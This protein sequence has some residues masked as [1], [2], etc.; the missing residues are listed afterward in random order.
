LSRIKLIFA[1]DGAAHTGFS[2]V[3]NG[4]LTGLHN[5]GR[6]DI[7]HVAINF[8]DMGPADTP[9]EKIAAGWW[10]PAANGRWEAYDAWGRIRLNEWIQSREWDV[11]MVLN[12]YPIAHQYTV[13]DDG[14]PSAF[15]QSKAMKV[16][17]APLDSQPCPPTFLDAARKYDV[18]IFYTHW[19]H[20]L[21]AD[22]DPEFAANANVLYHGVD[23]DLYKPMDKQEAKERLEE[24]FANHNAGKA[25][26]LK[27]KFLVYSVSTNQFRKDL[28]ALFRAYADFKKK[29]RNAFLIPHTSAMPSNIN[30]GWQLRNLASL[31]GVQDAVIMDNASQFSQEEMAVF[32][33]AADVLA[34]P[35][36]GEGFGIPSLEAMAC[37]TPVIA[38]KFGPQRE[39]H[40]NGRGY[41]IKVLD[42][43]PGEPGCLTYFALPDWKDLSRQL[44]HVYLN[45]D[46][47]AATAERGYEFAQRHSWASKAEQLDTIITE[48]LAN[49]SAS[50]A[51]ALPA[52]A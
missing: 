2:Q 42:L 18:N 16:L 34:Y 40:D 47:A 33:N 44:Y 38:T 11:A 6:Y 30:G 19:Q 36:R 1:G 46:E 43:I 27:D 37:K 39:L 35:T 23:L 32:M 22:L 7:T 41:F 15:A 3:S 24:I 9:Y 52:A 14:S 12:D 31:T 5:T 49:R 20:G 28:P 50:D 25:P 29:A 21:F 4:L 8:L 10:R 51:E 26:R 13:N 17:Y 48:A 45:R